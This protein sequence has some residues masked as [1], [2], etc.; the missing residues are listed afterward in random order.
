M[1]RSKTTKIDELISQI[2]KD[3]NLDSRLKEVDL[4]NSWE[5][6]IGRNVARTTTNIYIRNRIL[7]VHLRS[8]IVRNELLMVRDG[9]RTALNREVGSK[10][11]DN[12]IF[13]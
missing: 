9:L 6:V 10:I 13:R 5:K 7:Y 3:S 1:R 8:A 11:I 4:I 2:L 12:I